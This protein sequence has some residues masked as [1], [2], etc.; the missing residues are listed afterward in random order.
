[1]AFF[2][3]SKKVLT[4]PVII[5][6]ESAGGWGLLNWECIG[7][8]DYKSLMD[9]FG[10][11]KVFEWS[12]RYHP[13]KY[14][15]AYSMRPLLKHHDDGGSDLLE[16]IHAVFVP[17]VQANLDWLSPSDMTTGK[18]V[19]KLRIA[20]TEKKVQKWQRSLS[21][22]LIMPMRFREA[23]SLEELVNTYR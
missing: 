18:R 8:I 4:L 17:T 6:V 19:K 10:V 14:F 3:S 21:E 1:V 15:D 12:E 13:R 20:A 9:A 16:R 2:I 11:D 23:N 22:E 7:V 5:Q